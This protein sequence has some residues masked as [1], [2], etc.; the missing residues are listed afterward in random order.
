MYQYKF[1]LVRIVDADTLVLDIDFGR[2]IHATTTV[3]LFG[4]NAPERFTAEG[5]LATK[6]VTDWFQAHAKT[7]PHYLIVNTVLDKSDKYGRLLGTIVDP[8]SGESLNSYLIKNNF[9]VPYMT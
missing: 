2:Y 4:L 5:R 1:E 8:D 3:R 6:A 7:D 9:A